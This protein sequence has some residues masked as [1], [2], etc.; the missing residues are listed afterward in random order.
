VIEHD[1]AGEVLRSL[2]CR[3]AQKGLGDNDAARRDI[4]KLRRDRR[5]HSLAEPRPKIVEAEMAANLKEMIDRFSDQNFLFKGVASAAKLLKGVH[6]VYRIEA[7][8]EVKGTA[9]N[10]F[11][12]KE[13]TLV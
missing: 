1:E 3:G 7:E 9:L 2:D 10:P 8:A 12:T 5:R 4:G 6:S 13:I 11:D